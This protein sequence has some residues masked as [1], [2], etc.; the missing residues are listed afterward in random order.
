MDQGKAITDFLVQLR[1]RV[2]EQ[3]AVLPV[4]AGGRPQLVAAQDQLSG[5]IARMLDEGFVDSTLAVKEAAARLDG[6][7]A[8]LE[9][10]GGSL[11]R[12]QQVLACAAKAV[13]IAAQVVAAI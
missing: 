11:D 2:A 5:L 1:S 6:V 12:V 8:D 3:I 9:R 7:K 13:A 4:G 10:L